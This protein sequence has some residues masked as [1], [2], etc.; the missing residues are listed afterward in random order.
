MLMT[1]AP[2]FA[3]ASSS[4]PPVPVPPVLVAPP[5]TIETLDLVPDVAPVAVIVWGPERLIPKTRVVQNSPLELAVTEGKLVLPTV[6][7]TVSPALKPLP[8]NSTLPPAGG[9]WVLTVAVGGGLG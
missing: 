6:M 2:V 9:V 1:T 8:Q 5:T 4:V 3:K 7:V